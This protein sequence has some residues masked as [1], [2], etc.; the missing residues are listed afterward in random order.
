[1]KEL[2]PDKE[3]DG[4]GKISREDISAENGA[5]R[6]RGRLSIIAFRDLRGEVSGEK[7]EAVYLNIG[8]TEGV[9]PGM[10]FAV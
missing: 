2:N 6:K 10:Q 3:A 4:K 5:E 7:G 9:Q 8:S 1:M